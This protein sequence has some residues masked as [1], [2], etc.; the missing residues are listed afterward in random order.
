MQDGAV[1]IE[2][3][4]Q[5][6]SQSPALFYGNTVPGALSYAVMITGALPEEAAAEAD[7]TNLVVYN[8]PPSV[9]RLPSR[10]NAE[11]AR[12]LGAVLGKNGQGQAAYWG[13]CPPPGRHLYRFRVYALNTKFSATSPLSRDELLATMRGHVLAYGELRGY[14][15]ASQR[16]P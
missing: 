7:S 14:V 5:G 2:A 1:P 13:P 9:S 6:G 12:Q 10:L 11:T 3:T 8:I 15:Y 16:K 4:C